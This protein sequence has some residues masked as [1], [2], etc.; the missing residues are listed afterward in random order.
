[1]APYEFYDFTMTQSF[2]ESDE[3]LFGLG[4]QSNQRQWFSFKT[5]VEAIPSRKPGF[6]IYLSK[7]V[8]IYKR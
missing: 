7:D 3:S 8:Q 5:E 4:F 2:A 6:Y 1:M